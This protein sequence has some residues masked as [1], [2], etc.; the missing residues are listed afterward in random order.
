MA[1]SELEILGGRARS[2]PFPGVWRRMES[3]MLS[4]DIFA[5]V[6]SR[7]RLDVADAA[8]WEAAISSVAGVR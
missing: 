3:E 5:F 6:D 7:M 2:A 8:C 1:P 4:A